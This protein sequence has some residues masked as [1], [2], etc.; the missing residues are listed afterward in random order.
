MKLDKLKLFTVMSGL[1]LTST[2]LF[3]GCGKDG[4]GE[5]YKYEKWKPGPQYIDGKPR[6]TDPA[7]I[8]G[9]YQLMKDA[10]EI[11]TKHNIQYWAD[12]GTL[13]GALR[14][15]GIIPWDDDLDIAFA[16]GEG[17]KL[18][19][20][21]IAEFNALGYLAIPYSF[22]YQ[23][24]TPSMSALLDIFYTEEKDGKIYY[25]KWKQGHRKNDPDLYFEKN[26]IFPLKLHAFGNFKV[27]V[28]NDITEAISWWA[29]D[30]WF[31]LGIQTHNHHG[32]ENKVKFKLE[33]HHRKPAQPTGPLR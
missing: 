18:D 6:N 5:A 20:A 3:F 27:N 10:H 28:P 26:E 30:D 8:L 19:D 4:T 22:G 23:I 17:S 1:I 7:I 14:H 25:S 31:D 16:P 13:I 9:L 21:V 11:F 29:G 32:T 12:W 24:R 33:D 15:D 2:F